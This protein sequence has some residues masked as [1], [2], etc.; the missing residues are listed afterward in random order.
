MGKIE[1]GKR[2]G[3]RLVRAIVSSLPQDYPGAQQKQ[4]TRSRALLPCRLHSAEHLQ[5]KN[6]ECAKFYALSLSSSLNVNLA[7]RDAKTGGILLETQPAL[8]AQHRAESFQQ[9]GP[10]RLHSFCRAEFPHQGCHGSVIH[11][12]NETAISV[13]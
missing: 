11:P 3:G 10:R 6:W 5:E 4:S 12:G 1:G 9:H 13:E 8:G 2:Q 7:A